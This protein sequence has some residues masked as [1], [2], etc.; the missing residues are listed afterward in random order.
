MGF[1]DIMKML[2]IAVAESLTEWIPVSNTGHIA[3]IEHYLG[4]TDWKSS[5]AF[6]ELYVAAATTGTILAACALFLPN[7]GLFIR[8]PDNRRILAGERMRFYVAIL[9]GWLPCL[10]VT[11]AYGQSVTDFSYS[12]NSLK[13]LKLIIVLMILGGILQ[14]LFE[15][16]DRILQFLFRSKYVSFTVRYERLEEI[17]AAIILL[18][19]LTQMISV[20]PGT[21]RFGLSI[22]IAVLLG[23]Q[24]RTAITLSVFVNMPAV[25]VFGI[26]PILRHLGSIGGILASEMMMAGI[27]SFLVSFFMLRIIATWLTKKSFTRFGR[28]RIAFGVVLYLFTIL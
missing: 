24:K 27:L 10:F 11:L 21:C 3:V 5:A 13:N 6:R 28:Y 22:M 20:L 1:L 9:F 16:R 25:F 26:V 23:V 12:P 18:M 7:N 17:P 4:F 15:W 8:T 14:C 2:L 19:S